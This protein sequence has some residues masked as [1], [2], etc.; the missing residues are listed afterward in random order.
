MK[1]APV[2]GFLKRLPAWSASLALFGALMFPAAVSAEQATKEQQYKEVYQLIHQMHIN[3]SSVK[4]SENSSIEE[5]IGSLN[6]PYTDYFDEK[7]W[8]SFNSS[9]QLNYPGIGMRLG[10]DE[11][12]YIAVQIFEGSPA[13][14]AGMKR[15]DYIV[16]VADKPTA[17][18]TLNDVTELVRGPKGTEVSIT[19]RRGG[20]ELNLKPKRGQIHLPVVDGGM[21]E[22]QIGYL[23]ID[24]FSEDADELFALMLSDLKY[25]KIKGLVVDLRDNPGGYLETA[26]H[27]AEQFIPEGVL[28]HTRD[29][30]DI[31]EPLEILNGKT[32]EFPVVI[33]VNENSASASEVLT[34]AMQDYHKATAVGTKTY[35]KGSVQ[36]LYPLES[37]GVLKLTIQEYLS[38]KK[39]PVNH[40][41]LTPDVNTEGYVPQLLIGLHT[42][43]LKELRLEV[44]RH[45]YK[46]NG[47]EFFDVGLPRLKLD[48]KD[49][50]PAR[51]LAA[52]AGKPLEWNDTA[53]GVDI[54]A[55]AERI[56]FDANS[57]FRIVEGTGFI[58]LA[59]FKEKFPGIEWMSDAEKTVLTTKGNGV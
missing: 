27:I 10:H 8:N 46:V 40:V 53:A 21:M 7:E 17:D 5:L 25:R 14:K 6:D 15:G 24:S 33:L 47:L 20:E 55:G 49:Y 43:G 50:L 16:A 22:G 35:G 34:A 51:V 59:K 11:G 39:R 36:G 13:E 52:F 56:L 30:D 18:M 23:N 29:R 54:G 41:G 28:I 12:G 32:V 31:D 2:S 42:A 1:K 19:V 38:P 45:T 9:I 48:D 4:A 37:G 58:E 26:K 3:G 57:G 44:F